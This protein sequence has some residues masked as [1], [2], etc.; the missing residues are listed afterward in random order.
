M[1]R[2]KYADA[3]MSPNQTCITFSRR[4]LLRSVQIDMGSRPD[5]TP[6][7][8]HEHWLTSSVRYRVNASAVAASAILMKHVADGIND[9]STASN[10]RQRGIDS[11]MKGYDA[12]CKL[13]TMCPQT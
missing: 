13:K 11:Q 2:H 9:W 6:A 7:S 10:S 3:I 12:R 5:A 4:R 8:K 1:L